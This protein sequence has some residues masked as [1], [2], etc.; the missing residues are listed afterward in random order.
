MLKKDNASGFFVYFYNHVKSKVSVIEAMLNEIA[1]TDDVLSKESSAEK[2]QFTEENMARLKKMAAVFVDVH[3]FLEQRS[4]PDGGITFSR[5]PRPVNMADEDVPEV[6]FLMRP[7]RNPLEEHAGD[8]LFKRKKAMEWI[9]TANIR[10]K[11]AGPAEEVP[12]RT[13]LFL[14]CLP[15]LVKHMGPVHAYGHNDIHAFFDQCGSIR[16]PELYIWPLNVFDLKQYKGALRKRLTAFAQQNRRDWSLEI[17]DGRFAVLL[18]REMWNA[19]TDPYPE[20]TS[21]ILGE[22]TKMLVPKFGFDKSLLKYEPRPYEVEEASLPLPEPPEW[23]LNTGGEQWFNFIFLCKKENVNYENVGSML[24]HLSSMPDTKLP[25]Y[26]RSP[27]LEP[28]QILENINYVEINNLEEV[29]FERQ[30]GQIAEWDPPQGYELLQLNVP[31]HSLSKCEGQHE[32]M[33][34]LLVETF[35]GLRADFAV[36]TNTLVLNE[37]GDL[38]K[39]YP[40]E[41]HAGLYMFSERLVNLVGRD[42]LKSI[43]EHGERNGALWVRN[44]EQFFWEFEGK[45]FPQMVELLEEL[46]PK[47]G[48]EWVMRPASDE[49]RPGY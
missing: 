23:E 20:A 27:S 48:I 44:G 6:S 43:A 10:G 46:W 25:A 5:A 39:P 2:A 47:A 28:L 42:R 16:P 45:E 8:P 22:G 36:G 33:L 17:I 13:S 12:L 37:G 4:S 21:A 9:V 7:A 19:G 32:R 41:V 38:D 3:F 14:E 26:D 15:I 29:K 30:T 34:D 24:A 31:D 40:G 18:H 1:E 49:T 35:N 11:H